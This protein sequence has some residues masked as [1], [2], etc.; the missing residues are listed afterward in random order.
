MKGQGR[1]LR[2]I[3]GLAIVALLVLVAHSA[4]PSQARGA[5][6]SVPAAADGNAAVNTPDEVAWGLFLRV[7]AESKSAGNNDAFFETWA[8]D[9][10]TFR[11]RPHWP[12]D[13]ES[14]SLAARTLLFVHDTL[15]ARRQ[16]GGAPAG[17]RHSHNIIEETRHNRAAFDFIVTNNLYKVSGLRAAYDKPVTFPSDAIEVKADWAPVRDPQHPEKSGIPGYDGDP[18]SAATLYHVNTARGGKAY[19]LVG[20]HVISKLI[21][22]WTWATFEHENN[23]Q[24]CDVLGCADLFGAQTPLVPANATSN[25][26][27]G[28]CAKSP[29]LLALLGAAKIDPAFAH[30]CLKGTQTDLADTS[31]L[32]TRLGNSMIEEGFVEQSSCM[33][34][35]ARAAFDKNGL[36]T[37]NGG[38]DATGNAPIGTIDPAWFWYAEPLHTGTPP[39]VSA[40]VR[41]AQSA[42]FVWSIAYCAIDDTA[43]PPQ[44]I[45]KNCR[46]K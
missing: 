8:S 1:R 22:N 15:L 17:Q 5:A 31:G 25:A 29:A 21:P 13:H 36:A 40:P 4:L 16:P 7:V 19:A 39:A 43:T 28:A 38:F 9:N 44:T 27:Y 14:V 26:G 18:A 24:R 46:N 41:V 6:A 33:T 10:D 30:Y 37:S 3:A 12:T 42:D 11:A 34:C 35:H 32:A 2:S 20:L 23:P 45:S